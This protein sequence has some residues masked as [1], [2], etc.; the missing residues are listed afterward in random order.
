MNYDVG[1]AYCVKDDPAATIPRAAKYIRHFHLEDIA[2]TRVHQHLIPGTGAIDFVST[3]G[4]I[5][6]IGYAGWVTIELYPYV[7]DPDGAA[8]RARAYI[9]EVLARL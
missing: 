2:A 6:D 3:L 5:R 4:A 1:H 9:S 8:R 7:E